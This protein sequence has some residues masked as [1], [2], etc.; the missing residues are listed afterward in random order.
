MSGTWTNNDNLHIKFGTSEAKSNNQG[1][2]LCT[3]GPY[4]T[5]VLN[6]DLTTLDQTETIQNDVLTIP[7]NSLIH[8]VEIDTVVAAATGTA[9]D[10][11]LINVDRDSTTALSSTVSA[12]DPNGI[13][14]AF[15][16]ATMGSVGEYTKIWATGSL[17]A[18]ISTGGALLGAILTEPTL[19]TVSQTDGT[20]FTA[21][22][23][24]I[25]INTLPEAATGFGAVH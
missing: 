15:V 5:A 8:S 3:Y 4:L 10:V 24:Q 16:T 25:R 18:S 13:L 21:G 14:A 11:G 23:V 19:I 20:D 6:L 22:K 9:I 7:A 2:F 12:A 17:P 1:G